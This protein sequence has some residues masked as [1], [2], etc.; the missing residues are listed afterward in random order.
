MMKTYEES[1]EINHSL[2]WPYIPGHTYKILAI[3]GSVSSY[4]KSYYYT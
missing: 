2:N 4:E 3:G 1:V